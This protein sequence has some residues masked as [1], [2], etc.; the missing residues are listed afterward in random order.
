MEICESK[1]QKKEDRNDG[2]NEVITGHLPIPVKIVYKV[3]KAVCKINIEAKGEIS[4]GTGFFLNYSNSK[5][6]LM[7]LSCNK[8]YF[9]KR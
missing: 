9:R 2:K 5:K 6:Y 1:I 7:M 8:S 4:H 3:T